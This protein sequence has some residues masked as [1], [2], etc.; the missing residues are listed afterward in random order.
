M[1]IVS[2][3]ALAGWWLGVLWLDEED[4][5][6]EESSVDLSI[7]SPRHIWLSVSMK[8]SQQT[9]DGADVDAGIWGIG[10]TGCISEVM[11]VSCRLNL[12]N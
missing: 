6:D 3:L 5:P 12:Y 10:D 7:D 11:F 1:G 8:A 2:H 4:E 9:G